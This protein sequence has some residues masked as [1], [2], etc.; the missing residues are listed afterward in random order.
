LKVKDVRVERLQDITE[1][2]VQKEGIDVCN[3]V[4][5]G[6]SDGI[7]MFEELWNCTIKKSDLDRYGWGANP[8]VWV[9]EFERREKP[10]D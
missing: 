10:E 2:Q 9:I 8:W 1:G 3:G 7:E 6:Y 5:R 4:Y